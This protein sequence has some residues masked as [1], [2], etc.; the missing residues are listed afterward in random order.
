VAVI[1]VV[2]LYWRS[3]QEGYMP[4]KPDTFDQAR[5]FWPDPGFYPVVDYFAPISP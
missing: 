4:Y 2:Y 3:R 1:I 5:M